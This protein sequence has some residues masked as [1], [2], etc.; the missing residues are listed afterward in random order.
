MLAS[1]DETAEMLKRVLGELNPDNLP[2]TYPTSV[3]PKK[4][5]IYS[6]LLHLY[7]HMNYHIGQINYH[8]RL[9]QNE[10]L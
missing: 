1:I 4:M 5:T 8:R 6:F 3:F 9:L 10:S 2:K 7:G